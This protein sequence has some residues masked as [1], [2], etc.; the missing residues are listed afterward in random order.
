[1]RNSP[2]A[3]VMMPR[4]SSDT[5]RVAFGTGDPVAASVTVPEIVPFDAAPTSLTAKIITVRSIAGH[6][7]RMM[8]QVLSG[9]SSPYLLCDGTAAGYSVSDTTALPFVLN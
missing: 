5:M 2:V 6:P 9:I 1:M 3:P 7:T 4:R 8:G